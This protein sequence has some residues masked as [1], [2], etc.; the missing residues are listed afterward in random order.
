MA[1]TSDRQLGRLESRAEVHLSGV[2]TLP[3]ALEMPFKKLRLD[4]VVAP[5]TAPRGPALV[6]RGLLLADVLGL[7][8]AYLIAVVATRSDMTIA[9]GSQYAIAFLVALPIWIGGAKWLKLY[10]R[11]EQQPGHSTIDDLGR[12]FQL[13]TIGTWLWV[14]VMWFFTP[15]S[16]TATAL[17]FWVAATGFITLTRVA[18]RTAVRHHPAFLQ[19]TIIVGA[20]EVGQLVGR[21]LVQHP[22]CNIRVVG[23]VDADPKRMR[24]DLD[25]LP[26]L[27]S[28]NEIVEIVRDNNI[29][30]V[31]V[32][33]SNDRHDLLV[34]L[35]RSLRDLDVHIDLVPRLFEAVGPV[36]E[37]HVVEG[38][39]L[40]GLPPARPSQFGRLMKRV[41]DLVAAAL[42]LVLVSPLFAFIAWRVRRDSTGPVFF[43]QER[44]GEGQ[45]PFRVLKFRTMAHGTD[46][47][48]HREYVRRIMDTAALPGENN[49]YKLERKQDVTRVGA[50]LR[51]T[52]L[53]E[54][55]QLINI[56]RGEMSLVGPRPCLAY[57]TDL[58]EAHHFDR[59]LVPAGMT[60]L[61]QVEARAHSTLKEA[62]DLDAAY[63]RNRSLRLDLWSDRAHTTVAPPWQGDGLTAPGS[64]T[65]KIGIVGLGYWGPN[66]A[67]NVGNFH[68]S[69]LSWLCDRSEPALSEAATRHPGVR[70]TTS[71]EEMLAD[72]ELDAVAIVTPVA[73]HY[74]LA[75]A[76]LD[77]GKHVLIEKPLAASSRSAADLVARAEQAGLVLLPGHTFLYSPPV[78]KIKEL[79]DAGDLGELYFISMSRVNLGL[80]QSDVSVIWDL[81]PHDFSILGYWLGDMPDEIS[82]VMRS[83][84][85]PDLPDVA[86]MNMRYR[87]GTIA[88]L[89]L[90][91]LSPVKLR[92]TVI[93][94]S[95][96]MLIYDDTS[97]E[98]IRIFDSGAEIPPRRRSA[99][100]GSRTEPATSSPRR[101]TPP[102]RSRSRSRISARRSSMESGPVRRPRSG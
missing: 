31:I 95:R 100:S 56:L 77:A 16:E 30:R 73:T 55:P 72:D 3:P 80:H 14:L 12:I 26:I 85:L 4:T 44:L 96:K 20:G 90:S 59:F 21:K 89:E 43:R 42:L 49:L 17:C 78:T 24:G 1:E 2:G 68:R 11:D 88:H 25:Q 6:R 32:A 87:S 93:V 51:R 47:A 10:D 74:D 53:D 79:L 97:I 86:F 67:R 50:W 62:L 58:F 39:P 15:R 48:P 28:P 99:S 9:S 19:N 7:L 52:S 70:T 63:A 82:A 83:C 5:R 23:F 102:S 75:V 81:A 8:I 60:G 66:L 71:Y 35:V 91:W 64:E 29:H 94:G 38:L 27:G 13:V 65:V 37:V 76:A 46:E 18:A 84:V 45:K 22:E 41:M 54:L 33:F 92:R 57:E 69:E 34:K 36:V 61:W 101:S 98:P 40:V